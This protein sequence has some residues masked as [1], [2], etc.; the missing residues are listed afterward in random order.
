MINILVLEDD[1]KLNQIICVKLNAHGY[2]AIS[3]KS[4]MEAFDKMMDSTF[5]L[6]LS[7]I[8]MPDI[9]GFEFAAMI[10]QQD[11]TIP[12]LFITAKNDFASK[13][14]GYRLGIDD[15]MVKPVELDEM[16]LHIGA[17]LR[18]ANIANEKKLTIGNFTMNAD[19]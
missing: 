11:K 10:R 5:D 8:M 12:I 4:A 1:I 9:D 3:C 13:E 6:I 19:E 18:R 17:L 14:K 15:Y 2:H 7:D 16:L